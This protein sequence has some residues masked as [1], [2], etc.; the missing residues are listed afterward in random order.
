MS[1]LRGKR[2]GEGGAGQRVPSAPFA[3]GVNAGSGLYFWFLTGDLVK[4]EETT[5]NRS[6]AAAEESCPLFPGPLR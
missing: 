4:L 5:E 2:E 6:C 1:L 3:R